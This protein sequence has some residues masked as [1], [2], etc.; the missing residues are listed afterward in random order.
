MGLRTTRRN[1]RGQGSLETVGVVVLAAILVVATVGVVTQAS[2]TVKAEIGYRICQIANVRGGGGCEE[3][4][5]VR[6]QADRVPDDPCMSTSDQ[7]TVEVTA[8][9]VASVTAGKQFLIEQMS[10]GTYKV[11]E[12]DLGNV[13]VGVGPGVDV[14]LTL[15]GKKYGVTAVAT[16]DAL[17]TGKKGKTWYADDEDGAHDVVEGLMADQVIDAV[18][19]EVDI[20]FLPDPPNPIREG[21]EALIGGTP[22]PDEE[23]VE[24]GLEG[25]AGASAS[26]ITA[27]AGGEAKVGGYLGGKKTPDGFVAYYKQQASAGVWGAVMGQDAAALAGGEALYEVNMDSDGKPT[28]VKMT[29]GVTL[30]ADAQGEVTTA[31]DQNYTETTLEVP[32]TGDAGKDAKILAAATGN[33]LAMRNFVDEAKDT[34]TITQNEYSQDP[35]TYGIN[36]MGEP[37]LGDFGASAKVDFTNRQLQNARYWDGQSFADRPDC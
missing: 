12:V 36:V 29:I 15:D 10:D 16:A 20:P 3:P 14:S 2:P 23:F 25:N 21:L 26:G 27:G 37:I 19:P 6:T 9:F 18:A 5:A 4:G 32:L 1:E 7:G 22:D 11:T 17:L 8:A 13:G 30:D 24:G 31:D 35:N 33:P 34:G 28:S